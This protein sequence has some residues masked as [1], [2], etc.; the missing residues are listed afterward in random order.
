M[1]KSPYLDLPSRSYW[2]TGVAERHPLTPGDIYTKKYTIGEDD[3]IATA[4]SC[5]AQHIARHLRSHRFKVLDEE[6]TPQGLAP[7]VA[8]SFGFGLYSARYGNIYTARQLV[9]LVEEALGLWQP[10]MAVWEKDGRHFDALRPSV[11][12]DG[13]ESA[14]EVWLHRKQHLAAVREVLRKA[15][16]FVFT[17][18]LTEAWVH[19][20][21]GTVY[22]TA[23][24]TIAGSYD[25]E[26]FAFKNFTF[27]EIM[28]DVLKFREHLRGQNPEARL[29]LTVSPVPLTAT[30]SDQHVLV[31]TTYSKSVL[32]AVAGQLA[33]EYPDIDYFPSYEIIA[34]PPSRGFFYE[35]N[36]RSVANEGVEVVMKAFFAEHALP[37]QATEAAAASQRRTLSREGEAATR[38]RRREARRLEREL[39]HRD[40]KASKEAVICDEELLE[41]FSR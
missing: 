28:A 40:R 33:A 7:E 10:T 26:I 21:S 34:G 35:S 5:F 37:K 30:A 38:D 17:L 6:P 9:Q 23:P 41:A 3:L 19:K 29:L 14:E 12:P 27:D 8:R 4:G 24:G 16:V 15:T 20:E 39:R 25:P 11:E 2:R 22:P 13:L 31:A 1:P 18:G 32:R 36:L